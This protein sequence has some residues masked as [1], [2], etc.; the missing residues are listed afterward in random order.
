MKDKRQSQSRFALK[1]LC[2]HEEHYQANGYFQLNTL[3]F[4]DVAFVRQNFSSKQKGRNNKSLWM[5]GNFD[6]QKPKN[7]KSA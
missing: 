6:K 2:A 5:K 3:K 7:F 4:N 1:V